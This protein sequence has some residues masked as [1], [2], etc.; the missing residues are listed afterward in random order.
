MSPAFTD[1]ISHPQH[2]V[3]SASRLFRPEWRTG[4][5]IRRQAGTSSNSCMEATVMVS[6][7]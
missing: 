4:R 3:S 6:I 5:P 2:G 1:E 7:S